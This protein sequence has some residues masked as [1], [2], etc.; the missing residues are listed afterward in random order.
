M[1]TQFDKSACTALYPSRWGLLFPMQ[2]PEY[3]SGTS[4]FLKVDLKHE[5]SSLERR[6]H[7]SLHLATHGYLNMRSTRLAQLSTEQ[8]E[9]NVWRLS[10]GL[11][12]WSA[13]GPLT[14][15]YAVAR[16]AICGWAGPMKSSKTDRAT[17]RDIGSSRSERRMQSMVL[18]QQVGARHVVCLAR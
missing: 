15:H 7:D 11:R 13:G 5:S 16:R 14:S 2:F 6:R 4:G 9:T 17:R 1:V 18:G 3:P 12:Y 10:Q 8:I